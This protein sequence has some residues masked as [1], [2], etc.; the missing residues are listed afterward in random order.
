MTGGPGYGSSWLLISLSSDSGKTAGVA[1]ETV[2]RF[3]PFSGS[4]E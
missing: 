4:A 1:S 3:A 2:H